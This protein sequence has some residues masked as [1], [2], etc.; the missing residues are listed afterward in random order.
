MEWFLSLPFLISYLE[1]IVTISDGNA[2][3]LID[4]IAHCVEELHNLNT[5]ALRLDYPE[6][7]EGLGDVERLLI[8]SSEGVYQPRL[9]DDTGF[10]TPRERQMLSR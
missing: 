8:W 3:R 7:A 4:T 10:V 2:R 1:V 6:I 5:H 9:F